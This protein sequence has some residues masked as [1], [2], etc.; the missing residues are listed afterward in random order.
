MT[1]HARTRTRVSV[2]MCA[3]RLHSGNFNSVTWPITIVFLLTLTNDQW[4]LWVIFALGCWIWSFLHNH[5]CFPF[6]G[7][8][9]SP[10]KEK[11]EIITRWKVIKI[12]MLPMHKMSLHPCKSS[13]SRVF[14][15]S[16]G[17]MTDRIYGGIITHSYFIMTTT[18]FFPTLIVKLSLSFTARFDVNHIQIKSTWMNRTS[19]F[20]R[21]TIELCKCFG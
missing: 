17:P 19:I 21:R 20:E 15:S 7:T 1:F 13:R 10:T 18:F 6:N 14:T 3:D 9:W 5:S 11:S 8:A 4:K 16:N 12:T 2:C